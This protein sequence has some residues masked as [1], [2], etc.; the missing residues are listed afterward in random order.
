[1]NELLNLLACPVTGASD[2]RL[3]GTPQDG[4]LI[5]SAG[6][7]YPVIGEIPR[8]LPPDLLAP[9]LREAYPD[10]L[11]R[12]PDFAAQ[13]TD[14][15]D[16]E[17][18]IFETLTS[19]NHQHIDMADDALLQEDWRMTWDRFQPDL[20]PSTF[21]GQVVL[22]V[23]CGEGRH[24]WLVG[25]H[26]RIL[27]GMDLSRGVELARQ[28]DPHPSAYYVQG[29]LRRPPF[30]P[31][32][33]DALYSNGVIHHTPDPAA[34][35]AAVRALVREGGRVFIWVYGLDEMRWTYR[36]SHLTWLRPVTNRMPRAGQLAIAAGLTVAVEASLWTPARV[37]RRVGLG[38][39]ADRIP[40]HDA[41]E[42][43]WQYKLRRM[44]DRLN[45][46]VTH[47]IDR[48][49]LGRWFAGFDDFEIFNADGQ[50]W[51]ARGTVAS[52]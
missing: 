21:A 6:T 22:E 5:S 49:E 47:Y 3:K 15:P 11:T 4:L 50:G 17:P 33:F 24:A 42:K 10:F 46:P 43:K 51:S 41:A 39:V 25:E 36:M 29:D 23:G 34:S 26:A 52:R 44:F 40:Y 1:M 16:P 8:M 30:K 2:F 13:L 45:P 35:F 7:T 28:R 32:A 12:W 38:D 18:I 14:A 48:D 31:G 9:F 37:L 20:P 19:Y 27:V